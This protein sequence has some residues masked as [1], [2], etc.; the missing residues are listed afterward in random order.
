M[1][2]QYQYEEVVNIISK[3][4]NQPKYKHNMQFVQLIGI[5]T[6]INWSITLIHFNSISVDKYISQKTKLT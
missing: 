1:C 4:L 3:G 2:R 5:G 6:T